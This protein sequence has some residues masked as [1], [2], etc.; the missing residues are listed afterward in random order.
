MLKHVFVIITYI[1]IE[2]FTPDIFILIETHLSPCETI[3]VKDY[4]ALLHNRIHTHHKAKRYYGGG[5]AFY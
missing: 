1:N 2:R 5:G 4:T 3:T